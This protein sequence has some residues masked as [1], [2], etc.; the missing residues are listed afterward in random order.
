M[1][2]DPTKSGGPLDDLS[3]VGFEAEPDMSQLCDESGH[4]YVHEKCV[5]WT[6]SSLTAKSATSIQ[7]DFSEQILRKV[8]N[9]ANMNVYLLHCYFNLHFYVLS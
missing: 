2:D 7:P 9:S 1:L 4:I 6:I 8:L 3:C 5:G